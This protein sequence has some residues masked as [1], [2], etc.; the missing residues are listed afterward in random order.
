MSC[1]SKSYF[2]TYENFW[3]IGEGPGG[4][5]SEI[6]YDRGENMILKV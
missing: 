4:P 2:K 3:E 1:R 5:D 6:F